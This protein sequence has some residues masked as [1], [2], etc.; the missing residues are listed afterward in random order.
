MVRFV[1]H[2]PTHLYDWNVGLGPRQPFLRV[3]H[4]GRRTGRT[5]RTVLEVIGGQQ[6]TGEVIVMAGFGP[7]ADWFRNI[8]NRPAVEMAVGWRRFRPQHRILSEPE[9][10]EVLGAYERRHRLVAPLV[11]HVLSRL[12][13]WPDDGSTDARRRIV[14]EL[15]MV[16]FRP[17]P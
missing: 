9:A 13:G 1:L 12:V 10:C 3:V 16:A 15:P 17:R 7:S 11:G 5:Y 8:R 6:A 14:R 4:V 2:F